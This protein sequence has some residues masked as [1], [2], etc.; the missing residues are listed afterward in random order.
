[1]LRSLAFASSIRRAPAALPLRLSGPTAVAQPPLLARG[2]SSRPTPTLLAAKGKKRGGSPK[3]PTATDADAAEQD[4]FELAFDEARAKKKSSGAGGRPER[5][6]KG[7]DALGGEEVGALFDELSYSPRGGGGGGGS[8]PPRHQQQRRQERDADE[9]GEDEEGAGNGG[10]PGQWNSG[11]G[12]RGGQGRQPSFGARGFSQQGQGYLGQQQRYGGGNNNN[13]NRNFTNQRNQG[14]RNAQYQSRPQ[15]DQQQDQQQQQQQQQQGG[16]PR[17]DPEVRRQQQQEQIEKRQRQVRER[18]ERELQAIATLQALAED[19]SVLRQVAE[20]I[21]RSGKYG[22]FEE[23]VTLRREA[24]R[25]APP[26]TAAASAAA[27]E[28]KPKDEEP[29][30]KKAEESEKQHQQQQQHPKSQQ[31]E[32]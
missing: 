25:A 8:K 3:G 23:I 26:T 6:A 19:M 9:E 21:A 30:A 27:E 7:E 12:R 11:G 16:N 10:Q 13:N 28:A 24:E 15:Q 22:K 32:E 20:A 18:E 4:E 31:K 17:V 2:F 5:R 29:V 14:F 1:M